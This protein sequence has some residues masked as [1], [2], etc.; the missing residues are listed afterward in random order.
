MGNFPIYLKQQCNITHCKRSPPGLKVLKR[1]TGLLKNP[2]YKIH[3]KPISP[4]NS[5]LSYQFKGAPVF[6]GLTP[7]YFFDIT[8]LLC[9]V[10]HL[11]VFEIYIHKLTLPFYARTLH[12]ACMFQWCRLVSVVQLRLFNSAIKH[13]NILATF[14]VYKVNKKIV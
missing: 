6:Q 4:D 8:I 13:I 10:I 11:T 3:Y 1:T 14:K 9:A 5:I 12:R 2:V 7:Y